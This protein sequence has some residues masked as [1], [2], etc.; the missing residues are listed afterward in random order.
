MLAATS[1][2][3]IGLFLPPLTEPWA[4]GPTALR[5]LVLLLQ[6]QSAVSLQVDLKRV[7]SRVL[8]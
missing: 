2:K 5:T 6:R 1:G 8:K 3:K 7:G 4:S